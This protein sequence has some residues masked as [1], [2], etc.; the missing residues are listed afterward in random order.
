MVSRGGE[1]AYDVTKVDVYRH[2]VTDRVGV[3]PDSGSGRLSLK[4]HVI[5][6]VRGKGEIDAC[7]QWYVQVR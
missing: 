5:R 6:V 3:A 7:K 1:A 2:L 4:D